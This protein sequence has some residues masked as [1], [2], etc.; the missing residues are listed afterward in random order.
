MMAVYS[1]LETAMPRNY[2]FEADHLSDDLAHSTVRC[3]RK[4]LLCGPVCFVQCNCPPS[5]PRLVQSPLANFHEQFLWYL[6]YKNTELCRVATSPV[7]I[8]TLS[9]TLLCCSLA[10][11]VETL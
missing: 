8:H 2:S 11:S 1:L 6:V 10:H 7:G 9:S 3:R 5:H 4:V